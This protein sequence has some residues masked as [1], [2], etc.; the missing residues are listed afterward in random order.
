MSKLAYLAA[1]AA[2]CAAL[3]PAARA[4]ARYF[5]LYDMPDSR[6]VHDRP[7]P[8]LGGA[9]IGVTFCA[10]L[11]LRAAIARQPFDSPLLL[12]VPLIMA[13]GLADDVARL[14]V[15]QKLIGQAA[16][17]FAVVCAGAG[18]ALTGQPYL[19]FA[20]SAFWII[21]LVNVI[22]FADNMNGLSA[23]IVAVLSGAFYFLS[24]SVA[25]LLAAGVCLGYL[26]YN[27]RRRAWIF[28]GD[29]GSM[30]LGLVLAVLTMRYVHRASDQT[31]AAAAALVLLGY[32]LADAA[33]VVVSRVAHGRP[34]YVG[35]VDHVSH[36]LV[37]LGMGQRPA[38]VLLWAVNGL[39]GAAAVALA[40]LGQR[41]LIPVVAGLGAL[42]LVALVALLRVP[43]YRPAEVVAQAEPETTGK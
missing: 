40:K 10:L 28:M 23:G 21:T 17:A 15:V 38:V 32:P 27:F 31:L 30:A 36:R 22:N 37:R 16:V 8:L 12:G 42:T 3:V 25:A 6:K 24:G 11:A 7:T 33:L 4:L 20:I 34:F 19:D 14:N 1:A 26:P 41:A 2:V 9:A 39:Y 35:G 18:V 13:V 43:V 5:C 29:M